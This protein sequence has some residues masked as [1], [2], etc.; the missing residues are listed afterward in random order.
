[1]SIKLNEKE[2]ASIL[3]KNIHS[4][5]HDGNLNDEE[6]VQAIVEEEIKFIKLQEVFDEEHQKEGLNDEELTRNIFENSSREYITYSGC[7]AIF[8][9]DNTFTIAHRYVRGVPS[10]IHHLHQVILEDL[11]SSSCL[12]LYSQASFETEDKPYPIWVTNAAEG[13]IEYPSWLEKRGCYFIH[14]NNLICFDEF[15][16]SE[17][18]SDSRINPVIIKEIIE[19]ANAYL[20]EHP[21]FVEQT[22]L[23][24][25]KK[26]N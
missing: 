26:K 16:G 17:I 19:V 13:V 8:F 6:K 2:L 1:M 3:L 10:G 25:I 5:I 20:E 4:I 14:L 9:D 15:E 18:S 22:V 23:K 21:L 24:R 11:V 7:Y 12:G